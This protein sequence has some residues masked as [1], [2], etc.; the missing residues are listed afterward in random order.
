MN[1]WTRYPVPLAAGRMM[2]DTLDDTVALSS[3]VLPRLP[4]LAPSLLVLPP[5]CSPR[6]YP[7]FGGCVVW[8]GWGG[9]GLPDA[10]LGPP[11]REFPLGGAPACTPRQGATLLNGPSICTR[12]VQLDL[13]RN[14]VRRPF[15]TPG[16]GTL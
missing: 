9:G 2:H 15:P 12:F 7:G 11:P 1:G 4:L 14:Q 13:R 6:D 5:L 8:W 3:F 16:S 10:G